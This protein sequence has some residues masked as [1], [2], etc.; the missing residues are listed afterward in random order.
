MDVVLDRAIKTMKKRRIEQEPWYRKD[1]IL[2]DKLDEWLD[3]NGGRVPEEVW[4]VVW[5]DSWPEDEE[6]QRAIGVFLKH[7]DANY[8]AAKAKRRSALTADA[9]ATWSNH[10]KPPSG[11]RPTGLLEAGNIDIS[12]YPIAKTKPDGS[13]D[14]IRVIFIDDERKV[15]LI[16]AVT[17]EGEELADE[18]AMERYFAGKQHFGV[19]SDH[20]SANAYQLGIAQVE[21]KRIKEKKSAKNEVGNQSS[22]EAGEQ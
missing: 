18:E 20:D 16:P 21:E 8:E 10:G 9:L 14:F 4:D 12:T 15:F 11:D 17:P 22:A 19:F 13:F 2:T 3:A 6:S 7:A 5:R 1:K